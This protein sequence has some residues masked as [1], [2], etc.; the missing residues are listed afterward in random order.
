MVGQS[1][2]SAWTK[3]CA[4]RHEV[5]SVQQ[6]T[7]EIVPHPCSRGDWLLKPSRFAPFGLWYRDLEPAISYVAWE[8]REEDRAEI[9][10]FKR[11]DTLTERRVVGQAVPL[12]ASFERDSSAR[13]RQSRRLLY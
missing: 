7:F 8:V 6:L 2:K 3:S 5:A 13:L 10:V 4:P 11:D 12:M 9:R 1:P